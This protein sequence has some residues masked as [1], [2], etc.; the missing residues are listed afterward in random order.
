MGAAS[1]AACD[2]VPLFNSV[3]QGRV[4]APGFAPD[5]ITLGCI[6]PLTGPDSGYA[7]IAQTIDAYFKKANDEGGFHG[8]SVKLLVEDD[9]YWPA[10][11]VR[12][13]RKLVGQESVLALVGNLGTATTS[14]IADY[15]NSQGVPLLF[16]VSGSDAWSNARRYPFIMGLQVPYTSESRVIG[17]YVAATRPNAKVGALYQNDEFGRSYLAYRDS[18]TSTNQIVAEVS[19]E[20]AAKDLSQ[21]VRTLRAAGAEVLI[22]AAAP[23]AAG[24]AL[25]SSADA[26]WKPAVFTGSVA[27][28][29]S[30]FG[31]AG[32]AANAEGVTSCI[33]QRPY[34]ETGG[35]LQPIKDL[36][37]AY[38][39]QVPF[40]QLAVTGYAIA[41]LT[42]QVL[43][44]AGENPTRA[45]FMAAAESFHNFSMASLPNGSAVTT[46]KTD[47]TPIKAI[48]LTRATGGRFV[49]FGGVLE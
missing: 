15:L 6:C 34:N 3:R 32:G 17:R 11:T 38:S 39:P 1:L 7:T 43:Q 37:A 16:V 46:S 19:F 14:A 28:D 18:L 47:H 33:W 36:L 35:Q 42:A 12:A 5:S 13:A 45:R 24:L 30:L 22:L 10:N 48:Q 29:P 4:S 41:D 23:A 49:P 40:T 27:A 8:R 25:K 2:R 44:Q 9:A 20:P 31:L 26:G 21:Q